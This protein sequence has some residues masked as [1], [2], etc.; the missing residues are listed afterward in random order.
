[1]PPRDHQPDLL[2]RVVVALTPPPGTAFPEQG[3]RVTLA[4]APGSGKTW[5]SREAA[6]QLA[7]RRR[8]LVMVP[9]IDLLIQTAAWWRA[10]GH[11]EPAIAVCSKGHAQLRELGVRCTTS[12]PRLALW[13]GGGP[14][15]VF[16]TY[17]S[18]EDRVE[19]GETVPGPLEQA[20]AGLFGQR[21]DGFDLAVLDEA[22]R[23]SGLLGKPWAVIHDNVRIRADR[24]LYMTATP[25]LWELPSVEA[26]SAAAEGLGGQLVAS[27]DDEEI[28]GQQIVFGLLEA[29]ERGVLAR[30][31]I[32]VLEIQGPAAQGSLTLEGARER[33]VAALQAALLAHW[34][35]SGLRSVI[36][37][38]HRTRDAMRFARGL[39]SVA[40][41]LYE[42]D[43]DRYPDPV[44]VVA[45][46]LSAEHSVEDRRRVAGQF[47]DGVDDD[48]VETLVSYLSVC[49]LLGEGADLTGKR[50]V[51]AVAFADTRGS[52]VDVVQNTG[53]ALRQQPGEGKVARILVPIFLRPDEDPEDMTS[54]P[55][56]RPLVAILQALRAHD[57]QIVEKLVLRQDH[58]GRGAADEVLVDDPQYVR[59]TGTAAGEEGE[60]EGESEGARVSGDAAL[61][62]F[63]APRDA[64]AVARFLR[65]RVLQP[66]SEVWLTGYNLLCRWVAEQ[67][68]ARVPLQERVLRHSQVEPEARSGRDV[69][70]EVTYPLGQ[71]CA[72]QRRAHRV[73]VLRAWRFQLLDELGM[74][75]E[76]ADAR[77][78]AKVSLFRRYYEEH[79]TLAAP[80]AAVFEGQPIGQDLSNLRKPNGLGKKPE[81]AQRRRAQ[82]EA[83]DPHWNPEWPLVWQRHWAKVAWCLD[84]GAQLSH[85][86]PGLMVGGDDVG[87]WLVEQRHSWQSLSTGQRARLAEIGVHV[88][89]GEVEA[90]THLALEAGILPVTVPAGASTWEKGV[91]ALRQYK[92]REGHVRV[93]RGHRETLRI[94]HGAGDVREE[95]VR[96]GV[97]R[98]NA[99]NRRSRLSAEQVQEAEQLGLLT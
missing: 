88:P 74:E 38:H 24:R 63:F 36:T 77:F 86:S 9:T 39:P 57:E 94:D 7:P 62:R 10:A 96:L 99:R 21:L 3:L 4:S 13:G 12:A 34:K 14:V 89:A 95:H 93:P 19:G 78:A 15:T 31:E 28:Y 51:D 79:G 29:V 92:A 2:D 64:L 8:V 70:Q 40:R 32:D 98:S 1:M 48:G 75:W 82:L 90:V 68:H 23:T 11:T 52:V 44:G 37:F 85:L 58:S 54:S 43:P 5:I 73:G 41:D 84:G 83:I 46:W 47:A 61:L 33:R 42:S 30:F 20:M 6:R 50:G 59:E 72:E 26:G 81:R 69:G 17:N 49:K 66:Q 25:R 80:L 16:A 97:W 60:A 18:L 27:M 87:A 65:T 67:G 53:R 91:A 71:W 22:H 76:G 45:E 35:Q 55:S 56:Y